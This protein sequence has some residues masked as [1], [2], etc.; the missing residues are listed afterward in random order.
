MNDLSVYFESVSDIK[1]IRI[2][3]MNVM[4]CH[5]P[6]LEWDGVFLI[7]GHIH[8]NKNATYHLIKENLPNALNCSV[9]INHY[10]PVSFQELQRNNHEWYER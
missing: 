5:Y 2:E 7:H 10:E 3:K 1:T 9:D 8:G 6:L 4:L